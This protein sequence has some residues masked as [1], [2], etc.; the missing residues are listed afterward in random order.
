[1]QDGFNVG[2]TYH[3]SRTQG[4]LD[5]WRTKIM[6]LKLK[7]ASDSQFPY[8]VV[9]YEQFDDL[10]SQIELTIIDGLIGEVL[11]RRAARQQFGSSSREDI[12]DEVGFDEESFALLSPDEQQ[13]LIQGWA[14]DVDI[15]ADVEHNPIWN[16]EA[17][18][19]GEM[20]VRSETTEYLE[21]ELHVGSRV[22]ISSPD[23]GNVEGVFW[24]PKFG[25]KVLGS[26]GLGLC[27]DIASI[28]AMEKLRKMRSRPR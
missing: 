6:N 20:G 28:L 8:L 18:L 13:D 22:T 24:L 12:L 19:K 11:A 27:E 10:S 15:F 25:E 1:M 4:P 3:A 9:G 5:P 26:L 16:L 23:F 2:Q 7:V 21:A 17:R 14:T